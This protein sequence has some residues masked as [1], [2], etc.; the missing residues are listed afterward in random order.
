MKQNGQKMPKIKEKLR[1][2]SSR[3]DSSGDLYINHLV[4]TLEYK[5]G[6]EPE[7]NEKSRQNSPGARS[8]GIAKTMES[9]PVQNQLEI[10]SGIPRDKLELPLL[11]VGSARNMTSHNRRLSLA[12]QTSKS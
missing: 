11:G 3:H 12:S 4:K 5:E 9:P 6:G 2:F 8:E 1:S 7:A 10:D